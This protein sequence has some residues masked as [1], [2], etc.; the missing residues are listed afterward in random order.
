MARIIDEVKL[1]LRDVKA[2]HNKFWHAQLK[3]NYTVTVQNGR[4]GTVG[5]CREPK[6][7]RSFG[8]ARKYFEDKKTEKMVKGYVVEAGAIQD[9]STD[10]LDMAIEVL[11]WMLK[12][13]YAS[14]RARTV[15]CSFSEF[16]AKVN[17]YLELVPVPFLAGRQIT[18]N[19]IFPDRQS[20]K[21]KRDRLVQAMKVHDFTGGDQKK[22][23]L[24]LELISCIGK[25]FCETGEMFTSLDV[26]LEML[27]VKVQFPWEEVQ[28]Q[29][30]LM[31]DNAEL[32]ESYD[33][34]AVEVE[35]IEVTLYF[36]M[37]EDPDDYEPWEDYSKILEIATC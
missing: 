12:N 16:E 2:N 9:V 35:G 26:A 3:D 36:P 10:R 1:I 33:S 11:D 37:N 4:C 31:I 22:N 13:S 29:L 18:V 24:I 15:R 23:G 6:L 25:E 19:G 5:Q 21:A 30:D 20:I 7:F 28:R 32:D 17:R 27:M 14:P 8:A 34:T